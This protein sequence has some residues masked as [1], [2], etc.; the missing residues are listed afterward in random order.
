MP[1]R[2][3]DPERCC[4]NP[5]HEVQAEIDVYVRHQLPEPSEGAALVVFPTACIIYFCWRVGR[6]TT[7]PV[8]TWHKRLRAAT[9]N[10]P[11]RSSS[12]PCQ[13]VLASNQQT[14]FTGPVPLP[15]HI[16][17]STLDRCALAERLTAKHPTSFPKPLCSCPGSVLGDGQAMYSPERA[18]SLLVL[19]IRGK[20]CHGIT[21]ANCGLQRCMRKKA[22]RKA[23]TRQP[24]PSLIP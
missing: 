16:C 5:E 19:L 23:C 12:P 9:L 17:A 22:S 6:M 18:N 21:P 11:G 10:K 8:S 4:N 14:T 20:T 2:T 24:A 15:L 13:N 1:R 3:S 7:R